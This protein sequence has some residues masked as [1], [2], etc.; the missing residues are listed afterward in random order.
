MNDLSGFYFL[1]RKK[2]KST[3]VLPVHH[4]S[5]ILH[6]TQIWTKVLCVRRGAFRT[7]TSTCVYLVHLCTTLYYIHTCVL[8][9]IIYTK[10]IHDKEIPGTCTQSINEPPSKPKPD[11]PRPL[12]FTTAQVGIRDNW[13]SGFA[14]SRVSCSSTATTTSK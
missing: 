12:L 4:E 6:L 14:A 11:D 3:F 10:Y 5:Q 1:L 9:Y 2:Q 13:I 7:C 8:H